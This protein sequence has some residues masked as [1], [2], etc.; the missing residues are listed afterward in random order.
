MSGEFK[1]VSVVGLGCIG[2]PTAAML[3]S[4]KVEVIG[5]DVN[6][7]AVEAVN[8]GEV[9]ITE[10]DLDMIVSAAVNQGFLRATLKPEPADAFVVA[11]PTPFKDNHVPDL[12]YVEAAT[13][14]IAPVLK[15][16]DLIILESTS[17]VTTTDQMAAWLAK[18]ALIS[19]FR[20][21][22]GTNVTFV[23]HIVPNAYCP[24]RSCRN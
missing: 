8:R 11:V 3:A 23:L 18:I 24:A 9:L 15:K 20:R 2:L 13:R 21:M 19:N 5:V 12:T 17:P 10:P 7:R 16:G 1:K 4:R 6:E 22:L 14:A